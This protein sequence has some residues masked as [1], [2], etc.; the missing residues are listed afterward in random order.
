MLFPTWG[1]CS[2]LLGAGALPY[3]GWMLSLPYMRRLL[4][5]ACYLGQV[6]SLGALPYLG[7]VLTPTSGGS[8]PWTGDLPYLGRGLSLLG[9]GDFPYG[10]PCIH[11]TLMLTGVLLYTPP[12]RCLAFL[13]WCWCVPASFPGLLN[14]AFVACSQY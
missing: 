6:L 2:P 7:W 10:L 14:P 5:P 8:L 9:A 3:L 12:T 13:T 11:I 4:S 1:G